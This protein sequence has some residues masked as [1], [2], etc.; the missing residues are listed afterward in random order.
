MYRRPPQSTRTDTLFP[1]TALFR[2]LGLRVDLDI[3]ALDRALGLARG[4]II[5]LAEHEEHHV[6]V[7]LDRA[8]FTKVGKLR[9]FVIAAFDR[10]AELRQRHH[11]HMKFLRQRTPTPRNLRHFLHAVVAALRR[12]LGQLAL[13]DADEAGPVTPLPTPPAGAPFGTHQ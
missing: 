4:D 3:G 13:V 12:T 10:T 8:R 11:R 2:S 5:I 6:G 7:L 1:Y 9:T